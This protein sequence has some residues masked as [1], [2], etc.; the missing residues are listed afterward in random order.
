VANDGQAALVRWRQGDY[1]LLLCDLHMPVMD[2]YELVAAIRAEET[3]D[4][5]RPL[6]ALTANALDGEAERCKAAGFDDYLTK[7]LPLTELKARLET[8]LPADA[9]A[10]PAAEEAADGVTTDRTVEVPVDLG[11]L[12]RLVGDDPAEV[13]A[14]LRLYRQSA[15]TVVTELRAAREHGDG[16]QVGAAAHKLKS[17]A[18]AIGATALADLCAALE[19]AG[20]LDRAE[21]L[22]ALWPR[23]DAALAA[24]DAHLASLDLDSDE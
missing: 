14:F 4:R 5:R 2:G 3:A 17:S 20:D 9:S 19:A 16:R 11:A 18:R 13:R 8:W 6:L 7:P 22:E 21:R 10:T 23:F 15:A 1:T 24:V 12:T